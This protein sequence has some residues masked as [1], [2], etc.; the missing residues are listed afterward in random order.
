MDYE[1]NLEIHAKISSVMTR[2]YRLHGTPYVEVFISYGDRDTPFRDRV[3]GDEIPSDYVLEIL[4]DQAETLIRES[5]GTA[6]QKNSGLAA[7]AAA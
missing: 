2:I 4:Q 6:A 1:F 3:T 7:Q 5:R